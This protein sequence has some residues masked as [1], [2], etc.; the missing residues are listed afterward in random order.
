L[1]VTNESFLG[2]MKEVKMELILP[3]IAMA[4]Q[5]PSQAKLIRNIRTRVGR[6]QYISATGHVPLHSVM[7]EVF[8]T[9]SHVRSH[10][11]SGHHPPSRLLCLEG[12][13]QLAHTAILSS[14]H[15]HVRK[16]VIKGPSKARTISHQEISHLK[17]LSVTCM[18]NM[19]YQHQ[20]KAYSAHHTY[21]NK[22]T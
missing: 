17:T 13:F 12:F 11:C 14:S 19:H 4:N 10:R 6:N 20:H 7:K 18:V 9:V 3:V 1:N 15:Q 2:C 8:S 21:H 5:T 22:P 16:Q